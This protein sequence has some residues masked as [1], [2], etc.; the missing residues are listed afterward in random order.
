MMM[1]QDALPFVEALEEARDVS[2][3]SKGAEKS[4]QEPLCRL[5]GWYRL[6]G[7]VDQIRTKSV[8]ESA[9]EVSNVATRMAEP[10]ALPSASHDKV[11]AT[12]L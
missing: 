1:V 10:A 6:A 2:Q 8:V 4:A 11:F 12:L 7:T 3:A 5:G 9:I